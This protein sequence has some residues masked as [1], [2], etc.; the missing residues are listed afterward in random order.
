MTNLQ[1]I[2]TPIASVVVFTHEKQQESDIK[3]VVCRLLRALGGRLAVTE[4]RY[5]QDDS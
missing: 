5:A 1:G 3:R 2:V 4:V